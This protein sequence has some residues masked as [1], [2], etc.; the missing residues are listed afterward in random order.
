MDQ[1]LFKDLGNYLVSGIM[2]SSL[3][4]AFFYAAETA[5]NIIVEERIRCRENRKNRELSKIIEA[6]EDYRVKHCVIPTPERKF[7]LSCI[8]FGES[9]NLLY[10]QLI[11]T[12]NGEGGWQEL[13]DE[14][15]RKEVLAQLKKDLLI[16]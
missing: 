5:S 14:K 3:A 12:T 9:H 10:R 2:L 15:V 1:D 8:A 4:G 7:E 11:P 16:S 13:D 6:V